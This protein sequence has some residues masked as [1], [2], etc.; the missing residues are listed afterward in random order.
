MLPV[1][2]PAPTRGLA[3]YDIVDS[4]NFF[5]R[6][7]DIA[8]CLDRLTR[9]RLLVL[10]G[11]SGCGKS[12]LV[13][14]GLIP[15]LQR[16]GPLVVM[17]PGA[18]P[19]ASLSSALASAPGD[20]VV[21]VD[22][23][24]EIFAG[25]RSPEQVR[26]F[27]AR[28]AEYAIDRGQVIVTIRSDHLGDLGV[29]PTLA[30]LVELGL[31]LVSPLSETALRA[32]IEGPATAAGLRLENGL[33]ELL[34]REAQGEPGALPLLSHALVET[35]ERRDGRVLTVD[36]YLASGEIHGA[37]ARSAEQLYQSLT[38]A[39]QHR[40]RSLLL[41]LV[42]PSTTGTPIRSHLEVARL[43]AGVDIH[44]LVELMVRARLLTADDGSVQLAHEALTTA[45]PRLQGWV[46][47]DAAGL[48][49]M[50]HLAR[51]AEEW[52]ALGRPDSE[53][54]RGARLV[55]A[56]DW[57]STTK[58]ELTVAETEFLDA[59][60]A[61]AEA[62]RRVLA[63][64]AD[65]QAR[66]NRRLRWT[67]GGV[68]AL[69]VFSVVAGLIAV[70]QRQ[71]AVDDRRDAAIT[72]LNSQAV[73]VRSSRRDLAALL[74]VE[75]HRLRPDAA[76]EA[77]L[78]G[79]FTASPG[80]ERIVHTG[81]GLGITVGT[82]EY[83]PDG[84][85][86]AIGDDQGGIHLRNMATGAVDV[87][88]A[89][90]E[91][92]G[93]PVF[94]V[95]ADGRFVAAAWRPTFEPETAV[96]TVWDLDTGQARFPPLTV[97]FRIGDVA[98]TADGSTLI[99]SGGEQGRVLILDGAT[100]A[101]RHELPTLGRPDEATNGVVTA[102]LGLTPDNKL[103]V[104]SQAGPIRIVDPLSG[105]EIRRIPAP[106]ES[107]DGTIV[108]SQDGRTMVTA[109]AV[110][111]GRVDLETGAQLWSLQTDDAACNAFAVDE[112][113]STLLCGEWT[114][115]V[116]A[117]DLNTGTGLG[118]RYDSQLGDICALAVSPSGDRLIEVSSCNS[119]DVTLVQWRLDGGGPVNQLIA[120][121]PAPAWIDSLGDGAVV[122]E[123]PDEG[124][125][126]AIARR[127]DLTTGLPEALPGVFVLL[128]TEDPGIAVAV[129]DDG[130]SPG[131]VGLYDMADR[132]AAGPVIDPEM[133]IDDVWS[134]GEVAVVRSGWYPQVVRTFDLR[135]GQSA[136]WTEDLAAGQ[137]GAG[138]VVL[139]GDEA[140]VSWTESADG[141]QQWSIQRR[142]VE[143]GTVH[144]TS[145]PGFTL[146][147]TNGGRVVASTIDGRIFELDPTTL[148]PTGPPFPGTNGI[149]MTLAIDDSG[150]RLMAKGQDD[151]LRF[152]D[153]AT[154][155]LLG[156]PID[157]E[158]R[159]SNAVLRADGMLAAASS[160]DGIVLW[161]LD[162]AH[163]E[164]AACDLAGRNLT[165]AEWDQYVG[166]LLPYRATCTQYPVG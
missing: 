1:R 71:Q 82:A 66:Q 17:V 39:D 52:N 142:D 160:N 129:Y 117:F 5:G 128:P 103:V 41:R 37:V 140:L 120:K 119:D 155:T 147:T 40:V 136:S 20:P 67:L 68:A 54:Y 61:A 3:P 59:S 150:R 101:L 88:P 79:T 28:L 19:D 48:Q 47:D 114:G 118:S 36:G 34:V 62:E 86:V 127:I 96:V 107:S 154:R 109:G 58:P 38:T 87:L 6:D 14:A 2:K 166:D 164:P 49:L 51:A 165:R 64:Q 46:Q 9:V 163:W 89:L 110:S 35:W 138:M 75:A 16:R 25:S 99:V 10:A 153:I 133:S 42:V 148:Q 11:P 13:R 18:D 134:D 143:T 115:R 105:A 77:A 158:A 81:L 149:L 121:T 162:P 4:D 92:P 135:T 146:A 65:L 151:S 144:A 123:Y 112:S 90:S 106:P 55:T 124:S 94:D 56:A 74:A 98:L 85:R 84:E 12:S 78:F 130:T 161:D 83:L 159:D 145:P 116:V 22:Q 44:R 57:R 125:E 15:V 132:S 32:T 93:W 29:E 8:N 72:A 33:V 50:Q 104:G 53:L 70:T 157:T 60:I 137:G 108:I 91:V 100:G 69:L 97:D 111:T 30:P 27:C 76:S 95:A 156:D 31:H 152:F 7:A 26:S 102:A 113:A 21:V 24:E 141:G 122:A 139:S 73:S 45:W 80:A 23:L 63:Q 131:T 126:E 43:P